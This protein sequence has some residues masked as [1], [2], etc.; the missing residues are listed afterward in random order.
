MDQYKKERQPF[1]V[2]LIGVA[3]VAA[4][5]I[6]GISILKVQQNKQESIE[7]QQKA[8][9]R[10]KQDALDYQ[11]EQDSKKAAAE[12][13]NKFMLQLC[14]DDAE[15]NYNTNWETACVNAGKPRTCTQVPRQAGQDVDDY[16]QK[17]KDICFKKYR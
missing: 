11:K 5:A 16:R 17:E 1:S 13:T 15:A 2:A 14:L 7:R 10:V 9:L 3:I 8:E 4:S 12:A 6:I